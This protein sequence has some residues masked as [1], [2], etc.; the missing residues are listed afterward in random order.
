MALLAL[1]TAA[2]GAFVLSAP[3]AALR[4]AR[5]LAV[6]TQAASPVARRSIGGA[7]ATAAISARIISSS[8]RVG[9][10][11][12]PPTSAM[13][14]RAATVTAADGSPVAALIYDFE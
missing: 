12:P 1:S 2:L 13:A 14:P 7:T 5:G 8:A 6:A 4:P 9:H 3:P 11:L 10:N